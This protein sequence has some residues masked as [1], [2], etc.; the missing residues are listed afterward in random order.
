M[1]KYF[2]GIIPLLVFASAYA[3]DAKDAPI[4]ETNV[5]GIIIFAVLFF[6]LIFGYFGYMWW[7]E[8]HKKKD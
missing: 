6:G 4:P 1:S 5:I 8:K 3:Q 7:S 2:S